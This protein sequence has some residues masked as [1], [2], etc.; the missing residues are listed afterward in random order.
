MTE[1]L[2]KSEATTDSKY[3]LKP[4]E[5]SMTQLL[6]AGIIMLDKPRGPSSHQVSAWIK[7]ILGIKTGHGGT[8]DPAVSG[9]LPIFLGS[10]TRMADSFLTSD[11]EYVCLMRLHGKVTQKKIRATFK[12]FQGEIEQLPPVK[13]A[14][15]RQLRKRNIYY[16]ELLEIEWNDVLFKVGCEAG[17]YIRKYCHDFGEKIGVGAHMQELRRTRSGSFTE[18]EAITLQELKDAYVFFK[19]GSEEKYLR[20]CIKPVEISIN[21][22]PRI[23]VRDSAVDSLCHGSDLAVPGVVRMTSFEKGSRL[24]LLSLKG[25]LITTGESLMSSEDIMHA[26]KGFVVKTG[27]VFMQPETYPK[28]WKSK[29]DGA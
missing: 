22:M 18:S 29:D 14:V 16:I 6:H 19:D 4:E 2:V 25:E 15:K 28:A 13:C 5:R 17:T 8:L 12:E 1:L 26:K 7:E 21:K 11:K 24:A 27:R 10:A 3:G 20:S 9:V 23:W